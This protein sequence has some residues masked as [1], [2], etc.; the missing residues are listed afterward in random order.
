VLIAKG[1]Q[2]AE[3]QAVVVLNWPSEWKAP[4]SGAER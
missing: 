3:G 1:G 2:W 4:R